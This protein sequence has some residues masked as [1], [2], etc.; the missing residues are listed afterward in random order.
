MNRQ[1]HRLVFSASRG[2]LVAV[3]ETARSAGKRCP[4]P[5]A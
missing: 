2:A 1:A 3:G 4:F 5:P